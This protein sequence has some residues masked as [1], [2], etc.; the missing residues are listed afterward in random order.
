MSEANKSIFFALF[1]VISLQFTATSVASGDHEGRPYILS[2]RTLQLCNRSLRL[3]INE[4][5]LSRSAEKH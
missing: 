5:M 1:Y 4:T 3:R 2:N